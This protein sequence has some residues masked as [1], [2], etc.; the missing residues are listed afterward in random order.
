M[1]ILYI[2]PARGGSKGLPEKNIRILGD[3][4]M[5][6]HSI[7]AAQQSDFKGTVLVST[8]DKRIA[9]VAKEYDAQVPFLRPE[10]L[11]SDSAASI[12]AVFHALDFYSNINMMFDFVVLLQPTSPLRTAKDIDNAMAVMLEK[13]AEAVV[14]VCEAEH[15][16]LWTNTLPP[17]GSMKDFIREEIKGLN[18]QQLPKYYR[19]NGAIYISALAAL[20]KYKSFLH[21]G[22]Y[23]YIMPSERSVDIDYEIDLKL[24]ELLLRKQ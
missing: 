24:A 5:I 19:L 13:K 21:E 8:D 18:R 4:P 14:S 17:D 22:T 9:A 10:A 3:K 16:P 2:I 1:K 12:D 11:S 20:Y 7:V 15:H 23:S 6:A